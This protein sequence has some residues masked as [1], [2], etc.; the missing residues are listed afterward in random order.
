M[1]LLTSVAAGVSN[2]TERRQ[3]SRH[4]A[5]PARYKCTCVCV[6]VS[7]SMGVYGEHMHKYIRRLCLCVPNRQGMC[8]SASECMCVS[9]LYVTQQKKVSTTKIKWVKR[10]QKAIRNSIRLL[11]IGVGVVVS[12]LSD[13]STLKLSAKRPLLLV[14]IAL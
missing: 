13:Y 9:L 3:R 5:N 10:T 7:V 8:Q 4:V 12:L 1:A 14:N 6:C 2:L 11:D